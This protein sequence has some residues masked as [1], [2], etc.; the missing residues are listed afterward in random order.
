[1][2]G[3]IVALLLASAVGTAALGAQQP[4]V[5]TNANGAIIVTKARPADGRYIG[6][7]FN[8]TSRM[9]SDDGKFVTGPAVVAELFEDSP[10]K[11]A[12]LAVGDTVLAVNGKPLGE[13]DVRVTG[14]AGAKLTYLVRRN[15]VEREVTFVVAT[16][17]A[18]DSTVT[19]P[20]I[21]REE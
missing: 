17:R 7:G 6:V 1:M 11:A 2:T 10:A 5:T 13:R 21:R 15:G 8:Y 4:S 20:Q 12:G 3:R 18:R 16:K 19:K 14:P 9:I